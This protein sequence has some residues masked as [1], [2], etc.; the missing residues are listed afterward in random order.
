MGVSLRRL[1]IM[2][3]A[4]AFLL[5]TAAIAFAFGAEPCLHAAEA[6]H[7]GHHPHE[8]HSDTSPFSCLTCLCCGVIPTLPGAPAALA[9]PQL[10][11]FI[12]YHAT[13]D[14]ITGRSIVPDPS[15]P[16]PLA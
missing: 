16:R 6:G 13:I 10:L 12:R 4:F 9:A 15:P 14:T 1:G 7:D 2:V 11:A 5:G 8:Q 3:L